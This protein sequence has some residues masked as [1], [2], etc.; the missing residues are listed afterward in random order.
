MLQSWETI[1]DPPPSRT[2]TTPRSSFYSCSR[3]QTRSPPPS[4]QDRRFG[5]QANHCRKHAQLRA[6]LQV[7][8]Q[9]ILRTR[10]LLLKVVAFRHFVGLSICTGCTSLH[11]P[12]PY[13]NHST[14]TPTAQGSNLLQP[15]AS[16]AELMAQR[17]SP[18]LKPTTILKPRIIIL[19]STMTYSI[20]RSTWTGAH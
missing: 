14:S 15:K 4:Q 18:L 20:F 3:R 6:T 13:P 8:G 7:R 12:D 16:V 5:A 19:P 17:P 11:F 2:R 1:S 9:V 10:T